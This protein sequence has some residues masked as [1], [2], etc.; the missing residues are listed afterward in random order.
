MEEDK[1]DEERRGEDHETLKPLLSV[2][3]YF[4]LVVSIGGLVFGYY[5]GFII[6]RFAVLN[7]L[8]SILHET[9]KAGLIGAILG[10]AAGGWIND[11]L[12]RKRSILI[13]D[14]L[15]FI[16]A[17]SLVLLLFIDDSALFS[18]Y[19]LETIGNML[20]SSG[21]GIISMTS[22]LYISEFSPPK[23]RDILISI[24]FIF[25]GIG[26]FVF[27]YRDSSRTTNY[28]IALAGIPALLQFQEM[29]SFP[30]SPM[31]LLSKKDREN[32][33]VRFL[34]R[35]YTCCEVGKELDAFK[36]SIKKE[37]DNEDELSYSG[38]NIFC[39]IRSAW[40]SPSIRKQFVVG[41]ALQFVQQ[42]VGLNALIFCIPNIHRM[43]GFGP[44]DP[45]D[46]ITFIKTSLLANF[47]LLSM[48]G[49][50]CCTLCLMARFGKR[51]MLYLSIC[52]MLGGVLGLSFI[53]IVSPN[54]TEAVSRS[55][56]TI[57]F[58][59]TCLSY[60]TTEDADSWDCLT[61]I[62]ASSGCGFCRGTHYDILGQSSGACL[63]AGTN[64]ISEACTDKNRSWITKYCEY[65]IF[66]QP[67]L[68]S[69][70]IYSLSYSAS[71][72]IIPWIMN[73][74]MHPTEVR[75]IYGG[76]AAT[77]NWISFLIIIILSFF[78]TKTGGPLFIFLL[79]SLSLFF[80]S[81]WIK[82]FVNENIGFSISTRKKELLN[83]L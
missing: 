17:A 43:S 69:S 78:F 32:E 12:G 56:S 65:N 39:K 77:A 44:S 68:I 1:L 33:V 3:I 52:Y 34:R 41:T 2:I 81:W 80:V 75:G 37:T 26:K 83:D 24:N 62:R 70:A 31:W 73:S 66:G 53:F 10:A 13:A 28:A 7:D 61:C 74:Q 46:D 40:S 67:V 36:L 38:S 23:L 54:T 42:L 59:N 11:C 79:I 35:I 5:I 8:D 48:L 9:I 29:M 30:E 6:S 49:G 58:N 71:L 60:I 27:M 82:L 55:Q 21:I 72:E 47:G 45:K 20:I 63:I 14:A 15:I 16:G 22:P 57:Y 64:G 19:C 18:N 50:F 51:K 25:Y 4:T 76:T